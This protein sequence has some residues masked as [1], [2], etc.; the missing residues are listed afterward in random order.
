M[1]DQP[2][3]EGIPE[4]E[5]S[6]IKDGSSN[7]DEDMTRIHH[8]IIDQDDVNLLSPLLEISTKDRKRQYDADLENEIINT[9]EDRFH[10]A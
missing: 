5:R 7:S 1:I 9:P 6:A 3:M 4:G 10:K 8:S 2:R